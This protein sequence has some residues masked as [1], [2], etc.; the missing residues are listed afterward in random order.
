MACSSSMVLGWQ[1]HC[2]MQQAEEFCAPSILERP[3]LKTSCLAPEGSFKA[4]EVR[5][6]AKEQV[7]ESALR[8][9][10]AESKRSRGTIRIS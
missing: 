1:Y 9:W 8:Q 7:D 3:I 10:I 4:A 6:T 2:R 5:Y